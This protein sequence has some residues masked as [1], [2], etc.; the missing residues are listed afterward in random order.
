MIRTMNGPS[1]LWRMRRQFASQLAACSFMTYALCLSSRHPSRFQI[2]RSTGQIA[3]T[4]LLPGISSNLPVCATSDV[5]PF[6]LTLNMQT[7]LGP[8]FTEGILTSG[9]LAI[10]RSLTE[11]EV[12]RIF[13]IDIL[14]KLIPLQYALEQQLCLFG[15]DE[16]ISWMT[17]QRRPWTV[18]DAAFRQG[19][20]A[21]I[22]NVV[23][24]TE[25]MA[26]KTERENVSA[27]SSCLLRHDQPS[28]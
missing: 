10:A 20:A 22:D 14:K 23:K 19:V 2:C 21:N 25:V 28:F 15:R 12:Q 26:C 13:V 11:P 18:G 7:F 17:M 16:V 1:E 3:M 27:Q 5:V 8:I 6:R 24:R 4:E 9:I